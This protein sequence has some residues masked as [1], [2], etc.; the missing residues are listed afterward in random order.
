MC[1]VVAFFNLL[2]IELLFCC[3][4]CVGI[5]TG[6]KRERRMG[7]QGSETDDQDQLQTGQ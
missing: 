7:L 4:L 1:D 5:G 3:W 6:R 2:F